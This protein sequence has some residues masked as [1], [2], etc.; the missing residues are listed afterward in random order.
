MPKID[1]PCVERTK[2]CSK[3]RII[4]LVSSFRIY[5]PNGKRKSPYLASW[6]RDCEH[7]DNSARWRRHRASMN[8]RPIVREKLSSSLSKSAERG[9][10]G[11]TATVEEAIDSFTTVCQIC[12][13][14]EGLR[15]HL[16]HCGKTG[17]LRG[18]LCGCCNR[19]LGYFH[20]DPNKLRRAIAY[21]LKA[22][23]G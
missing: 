2:K 10:V 3:C 1:S 4:K 12:G 15:I 14:D 21:L 16:D 8:L 5:K 23:F 9:L 11:C 18:W 22:S 13:K 20:D 6:C 17:R 7:K 19:A